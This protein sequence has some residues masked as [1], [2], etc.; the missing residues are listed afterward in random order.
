VT[1]K[2]RKHSRVWLYTQYVGVSI[3]YLPST[4]FQQFGGLL[5]APALSLVLTA[6][7]LALLNLERVDARLIFSTIRRRG[8]E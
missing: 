3:S 2:L 1:P 8:T 5:K 6:H 4:N 7:E